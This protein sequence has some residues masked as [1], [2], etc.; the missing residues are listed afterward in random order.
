MRKYVIFLLLG[1]GCIL[2]PD[3]IQAE[4]RNPFEPQLPARQIE[5]AQKPV[6]VQTRPIAQ[7]TPERDKLAEQKPA[8]TAPEEPE[9]IP[10]MDIRGLVWNSDRPQAIINNQVIDIGDIVGDVQIIGIR[11]NEIDVSFQGRQETI[12]L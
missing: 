11:K 4:M 9:A 6:E 1:L 8:I 3:I 2:V 10:E 5:P 7:R 12:K